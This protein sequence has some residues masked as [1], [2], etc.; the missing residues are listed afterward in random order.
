L[1]L[2][3]VSTPDSSGKSYSEAATLADYCA[4]PFGQTRRKP[5]AYGKYFMKNKK[6][7][8]LICSKPSP[9]SAF[10]K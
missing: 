4:T 2:L 5:Q 7:D 9:L 8:Y 3:I 10:R 6:A 1:L